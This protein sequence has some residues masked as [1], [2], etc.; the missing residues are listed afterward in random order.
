M[1]VLA[2]TTMQGVS[3]QDG[4][5]TFVD[6]TNKNIKMGNGIELRNNNGQN[7]TVAIGD[8]VQVDD[9]VMQQGSVAIGNNAF[10]ENMWG[11]QE[12]TFRFGMTENKDLMAGIAIG[13]NTYA[14]SGIQ[15]GDHK[16]IGRLGDTTVNPTTDSAKRNLAI[17]MGTTTLGHN[18]YSNGA[19]TTNTGAFSIMTNGYET[20]NAMM[21]GQNFG[22][23]INGS[24]NS[25][26]SKTSSN[27]YSGI[28]NS[29]VG[30]VNRVN[31]SNG[32]LIFGAGNEVTNS[33]EN[34]TVPLLGYTPSDAKDL[35]DTLRSNIRGTDGNGTPGGAVLAIGGGNKVDYAIRSQVS[36]VG[37]TL[38]GTSAS[39]AS[40]NMLNG[41][42]NKGTT[43]SY[44]TMIGTLNTI[45]NGKN[46]II[47]GNKQKLTSASNNIILGTADSETETTVSDAVVIGHNGKTSVEGGVALGSSSVASTALGQQGYDPSAKANSTS[48]AI[49]WK[50]T[51]GAV[52]VGDTSKN[53]TRQITGV[54]AGT[55]DTDAVNVAQLKAIIGGGSG[56][57]PIHFFSVN[58]D[59]TQ[60]NYNN[61]GATGTNAV[62]IGTGAS[63]TQNG[64]IAIGH[65]AQ[66][67]G[68]TA[69]AL[70]F[71]AIAAGSSTVIGESSIVNAPNA[72]QGMGS[73]IIGTESADIAGGKDAGASND[74]IIGGGNRINESNGV[75]VRGQ[76]NIVDNAY[77]MEALTSEDQQKLVAQM[78]MGTPAGDVYEKIGS[79]VSVNG[80]GNY[81]KNATFS[82]I[83]GTNNQI[84]GSDDTSADFNIVTG[85][86]NVVENSTYNIVTGD[87]YKITGANNNVILGSSDEIKEITVSDTVSIGHNA[88]ATVEGGVALGANSVASVAAGVAGYNPSSKAVTGAAWTSTAAAVSVGD[89]ANNITRQITGVAAGKEDTDAVNVAQ[90]KEAYDGISKTVNANKVV[91]SDNIT[92]TALD[93]GKGTQVSLNKD[94]T[95]GDKNGTNVAI[96]GTDGKITASK[97][98][99]TVT[100]DGTGMK[101]GG[102]PSV[103]KDGIDG[104][105]KTITN[106][107]DGVNANDAVN[108]GQLNKIKQELTDSNTKLKDTGNVLSV[109]EAKKTLNLEIQDTAGTIVKG[110]VNLSELAGAVDT[111][112]RN[113]IT[114]DDDNVVIDDSSTNDDGSTNYKISVK[115]DGKVESGNTGIVTGGTVFSET[116]VAEGG[117]YNYISSANS[118]ADNLIA[119]DKQVGTNTTSI[120]N[121]N[122]KMNDLGGRVDKV[123]A[124]SAALAALH[125]LD[126]DPEDK[127]NF[128]AGFGH[129]KSESSAAL[130][131]FYRMNEDTMFSVGGTF[132][133]E[134]MWN[135]GVSVKLGSGTTPVGSRTVMAKQIQELKNENE[136][137]RGKNLTIEAENKEIKAE[138]K[139]IKEEN[140]EIKAELA[141][142]KQQIA[143]L[144]AK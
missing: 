109:D 136:A 107:A 128:A 106:V 75:F 8:H 123:G 122:V 6:P 99:D 116:R 64:A 124:S 19:F 77:K 61:D 101:I 42:R 87:K 27:M 74:T 88:N 51:A 13:Q 60:G 36:G 30:T 24:F 41:Y 4:V 93:D 94:I 31:N 92:V 53:I 32:T 100:I 48:S 102:G 70:G 138:N 7:G 115:T 33:V 69:I 45:T 5:T 38:T 96:S 2:L 14:R 98:T 52:S 9:Y 84:I 65:I 50:S 25:I 44:A 21:V 127:W 68:G 3:A 43:T 111:D 46:N 114:T 28:A 103:T 23:V 126:F 104:G 35:A 118:A 82:Q 81:V 91:G 134:R 108:V 125:P 78:F 113:T 83:S 59:E 132:G 110:S 17:V 139:E 112:T 49:A 129:Y 54:A 16:Y 18:S 22:A 85:N 120:T 1:T 39:R 40:Y 58:G 121:L 73:V 26:E 141:V 130:G 144:M 140:K 72:G 56:G 34:I 76:G 142:L 133:G 131:A 137:I 20:G 62:A 57:T 67:T 135:A 12:R 55:A 89:V 29:V 119:L 95:L 143:A 117:N 47:V 15:I 66:A 105:S 63:A 86:R 10:V 80:D 97:G 71:N 37:N 90:L 79:H 11:G